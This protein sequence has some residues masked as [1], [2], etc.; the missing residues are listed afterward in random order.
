MK[1][2]SIFKTRNLDLA[3]VLL[4]NGYV[5]KTKILGRVYAEFTFE[6]NADVEKIAN[7]FLKGEVSVNI[8]TFMYSRVSLKRD[9]QQKLMNQVRQTKRSSYQL[10][11]FTTGEEYCFIENGKT[12]KQIFTMKEPHI[13]R[14]M[15]GR[16]FKTMAEALSNISSDNS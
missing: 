7:R 2:S 3:S 14:V 5:C 6:S 10:S 13:N 11:D 1:N 15:Q 16:A 12:Y 8:T 4:S 9:L